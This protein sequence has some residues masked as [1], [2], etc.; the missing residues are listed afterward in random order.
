MMKKSTAKYIA[1]FICLTARPSAA[2]CASP[3]ERPIALLDLHQ[4]QSQAIQG[5]LRVV[6]LPTQSQIVT[7]QSDLTGHSA[8]NIWRKRSRAWVKFT[9]ASP[10]PI[11]E[12]SVSLSTDSHFLLASETTVT[13]GNVYYEPHRLFVWDL[14]TLK[15]IRTVDIGQSSHIYASAFVSGKSDQAILTARDGVV[16]KLLRVNLLTGK[17]LY[18]Q[19]YPDGTLLIRDQILFSPQGRS[20]ACVYPA[21]EVSPNRVDFFDTESGKIARTLQGSDSVK[22]EISV[23]FFF[24]NEEQFICGN[25]IYSIQTGQKKPLFSNHDTRQRCI[26]GIPSRPGYAF[27]LAKRGLELW[28][29]SAQRMLRR[30][31]QIKKVDGIYFS[32][33][34]SVMG[35]L[36]GHTIRFWKFDTKII[37]L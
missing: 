27:F 5:D 29:I 11:E 14:H 7:A 16:N 1:V 30:W 15:L 9:L 36:D 21:G 10:T 18:E 17:L 8:I 13:N 20:M 31:L 35:V 34:H 24:L 19:V 23:P 33:D 37:P 22:G 12:N 4:L 25:S 6:A 2:P 32:R 28:S 3:V 26:S